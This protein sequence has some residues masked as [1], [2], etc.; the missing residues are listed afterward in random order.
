MEPTQRRHCRAIEVPMWEPITVK[1]Q[2]AV[3]QQLRRTKEVTIMAIS[4]IRVPK[5]V[6][7]KTPAAQPAP[8]AADEICQPEPRKGRWQ[9]C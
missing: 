2:V 6:A 8:A 4:Q 9:Y 5:P 7:A 3:S 1:E